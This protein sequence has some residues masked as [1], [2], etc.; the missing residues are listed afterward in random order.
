MK[1]IIHTP[2]LLQS[3]SPVHN[4]SNKLHWR[5]QLTKQASIILMTLFSFSIL[6]QSCKKEEMAPMT[7]SKYYTLQDA[8]RKLWAD[9][10][11]YT[12]ATVD[13]YYNNPSGLSSSLDRLLQN[14]KDIGNAIVPYYG[15][16][17]GDTLA[18]LLT[19]H[20]NQAVPVLQAAKD[21]DQAALNQALANWKANAKDIAIFLT[22]ANPA[23]WQKMDMEHM[24]EMHIDQ[25]TTYAVDLL[26][27]DYKNAISHYDEAYQHMMEMADELTMGI[28]SQFPSKF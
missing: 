2:A 16:A 19:T 26:K 23:H 18:S 9:H 14:Q 4:T 6:T 25:T 15:Q 24:M 12:Y 17:A 28:S 8:M 3:A 27:K 10:M 11:Q 5:W 13:A 21:N 7:S 20:I 22:T 1:H